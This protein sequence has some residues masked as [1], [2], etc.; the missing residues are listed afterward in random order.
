MVKVYD[1]LCYNENIL[2]FALQPLLAKHQKEGTGGMQQT[3]MIYLFQAAG[4]T[5]KARSS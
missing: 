5:W 1:S 4:I 3:V 2:R